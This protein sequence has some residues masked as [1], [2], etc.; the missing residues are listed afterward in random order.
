[1]RLFVSIALTGE[2][3]RQQSLL[4]AKEMKE[5]VEAKEAADITE[6][7]S[8]VDVR[9]KSSLNVIIADE[10]NWALEAEIA[11]TVTELALDAASTV[12]EGKMRHNGW[13]S[14]FFLRT[15]YVIV[16]AHI[17]VSC[18]LSAVVVISPSLYLPISC[19]S[20]LYI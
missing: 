17:S 3:G 20:S 5:K 18:I 19:P 10:E 14:V 4:K 7:Y 6:D 2:R 15:F 8:V 9:D 13:Y 11:A 12:I 16:E 1:V